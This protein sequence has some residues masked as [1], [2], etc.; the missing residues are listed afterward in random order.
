MKD[1]LRITVPIALIAAVSP[2]L[3]DAQPGTCTFVEGKLNGH[4][5]GEARPVG[6]G[7]HQPEWPREGSIADRRRRKILHREPGSRNL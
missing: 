7:D 6:L 2:G 1:L 5:G 4:I 3:S